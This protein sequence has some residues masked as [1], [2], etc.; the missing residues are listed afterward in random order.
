MK[1]CNQCGIEKPV[2]D[3]YRSSR[4]P[5]GLQGYCKICDKTRRQSPKVKEAKKENAWRNNLKQY[6]ITEADYEQ[7]YERQMGICAICHKPETDIRLAVDHDHATGKVRGLL[8]KRCNMAI[9]LLGDDPYVVMTA[10]LYL[11]GSK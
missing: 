11:K 1:R 5:D 9:G 4:S 10:A 6:G 7:M 2:E 3:F 8:C